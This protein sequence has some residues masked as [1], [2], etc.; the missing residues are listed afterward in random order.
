MF[1]HITCYPIYPKSV[2]LTWGLKSS[3]VDPGDYSYNVYRSGSPEGPWEKLNSLPMPNEPSYSDETPN[4]NSKYR[5]IYYFVEAISGRGTVYTSPVKNLVRNVERREYVKAT[6]INRQEM[7]LLR[8]YAGT[9]VHIFKKKHYGENCSCYD[10]ITESIMISD[11]KDCGGTRFVGGYWNPIRTYAAISPESMGS[12]E[13]SELKTEIIRTE[14]WITAYPRVIDDDI[15]V[16][17]STNRRWVIKRV[18]NTE[19]R[20]FPVKQNLVLH[21]LSR[22]NPEYSLCLDYCLNS[23]NRLVEIPDHKRPDPSGTLPNAVDLR[24]PHLND[25]L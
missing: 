8:Q 11:C 6:E 15:L 2:Y 14:A 5:D 24:T 21:E 19:L 18:Q 3:E 20:R 25:E 17:V 12:N 7:V 4:L 16:E 13:N 10:P 1:T 22:S 23:L 9:E